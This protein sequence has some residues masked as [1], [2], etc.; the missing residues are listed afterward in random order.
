MANM[1]AEDEIQIA[2][3][4]FIILH[5]TRKNGL[6]WYEWGMEDGDDREQLKRISPV[7][8]IV[9]K[10]RTILGAGIVGRYAS[11]VTLIFNY[12]LPG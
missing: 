2:P 9:W 4:R 11:C 10:N 1:A 8:T 7:F 3:F 6:E 5:K 12:S